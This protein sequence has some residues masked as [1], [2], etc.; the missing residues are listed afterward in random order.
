MAEVQW[1]KDAVLPQI[2]RERSLSKSAGRWKFLIVGVVLLGAIAYLLLNGTLGARYYV[3][4]DELLNNAD[5]HGKSVR[6]S[7][8]VI[9][10]PKFNAETGELSFVVANIPNDSDEIKK[11]GGLAAVL[12]KASIDPEATR[13]QVIAHDKE[14]PDLLKAE[15][16]A[17]MSGK[18]E[19][20]ADGTFI[21]YADEITL[22]CPTKYEDDVPNQAS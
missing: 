8:A 15:A 13:M 12:H 20:Q 1:E 21:F 18:L 11:Q 6:V 2:P 3:T 14:I 4:V 17:I 19:K 5:M 10:D 9:S 16:Q 22:K 7:G